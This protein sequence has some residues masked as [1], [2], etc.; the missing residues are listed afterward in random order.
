MIN[1]V[2]FFFTCENSYH[3][4]WHGSEYF[5]FTFH[6]SLSLSLTLSL[7]RL[8][9]SIPLALCVARSLSP[10]LPLY[11]PSSSCVPLYHYLKLHLPISISLLLS[12][13]LSP[14]QSHTLSL[15]YIAPESA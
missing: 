11:L 1:Y 4:F 8:S 12:V 9:L 2:Y 6:S 13:L 3:V 14:T 10:S 7:P 5:L 15:I